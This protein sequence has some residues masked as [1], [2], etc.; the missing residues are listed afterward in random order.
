MF[1]ETKIVFLKQK[2]FFE[3]KIVFFETKVVFWNKNCFF[4]QKLFFIQKL[5]FKQKMFLKQKLL[6]SLIWHT[7]FLSIFFEPKPV[8]CGKKG[9]GKFVGLNLYF[10]F[11]FKTIKNIIFS[12]NLN[13]YIFWSKFFLNNFFKKKSWVRIFFCRD[14]RKN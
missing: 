13:I 8:R 5:F 12:Q 14:V 6:R 3:T 4:K 7:C 2:L 11:K 9:C 1:F 10:R